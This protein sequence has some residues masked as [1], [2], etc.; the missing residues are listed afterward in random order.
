M[1]KVELILKVLDRYFPKRKRNSAF[2]VLISCIISQRTREENT[3]KACERLFKL[4]NTPEDVLKLSL[5]EL[6]NLLR[7][8]GFY[9]QKAKR[10][11]DVCRI[12]VEKYNGEVPKTRDELM[13]LPGVGFK[14]SAV[15]LAYGFGIPIIAVDTHVNRI[16]KRLGLVSEKANVEEVRET[17]QSLFPKEKWFL[18]NL[19]MVNFGREVCK[20]IKPNCSKCELKAI[21]EFYSK[22]SQS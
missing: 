5:K 16:S 10:I 1:K 18:I 12:L 21:C 7:P 8:A 2:K 15:V 22:S 20:P 13:K 3:E 14:T 17:L 19:A 11:K 6:E 4:V 9:R